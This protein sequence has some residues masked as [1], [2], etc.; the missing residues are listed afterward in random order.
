MAEEVL[1]ERALSRM[2]A[3]HRIIAGHYRVACYS[4]FG[5]AQRPKMV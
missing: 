1:S 4:R 2:G 5:Q 3:G